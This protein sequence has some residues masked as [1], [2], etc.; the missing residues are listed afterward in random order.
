M[1]GRLI[2]LPKKSWHVW[3]Q[4]NLERVIRDERLAAEAKEKED[5]KE[6]D[7]ETEKRIELISKR[8]R[9]D[10]AGTRKVIEEK[11]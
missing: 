5:I 11:K 1:S 3:R 9:Q 8:K 10:N 6:R 2:I 4:D 7:A